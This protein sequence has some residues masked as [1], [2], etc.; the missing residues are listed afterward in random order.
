MSDDYRR[1]EVITGTARRRCSFKA[2]RWLPPV[3]S[4][5]GNPVARRPHRRRPYSRT[6]AYEQARPSIRVPVPVAP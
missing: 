4:A 3:R 2:N 1:I 5:C 6:N